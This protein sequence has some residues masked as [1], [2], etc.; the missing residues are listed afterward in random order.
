M[1]D[2]RSG[3]VLGDILPADPTAVSG[4]RVAVVQT[5]AKSPARLLVANGTGGPT[6]VQGY[7]GIT[8]HADTLFT[9][10]GRAYGLYVG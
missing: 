6:A 8:A 4:A 5:G 3:T 1:F 9:D 7:L 2:P 10:P